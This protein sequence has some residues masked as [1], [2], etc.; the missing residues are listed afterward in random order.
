MLL[1]LLVVGGALA[2]VFLYE[3]WT[4]HVRNH[5]I[6]QLN[7]EALNSRMEADQLRYAFR[8]LNLSIKGMVTGINSS[9]QEHRKAF[10]GND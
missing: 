4:N 6:E 5:E 9:L 1:L 7:E 2:V 3:L 8:K 10:E